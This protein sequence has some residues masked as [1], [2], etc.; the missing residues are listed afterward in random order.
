MAGIVEPQV[1]VSSARPRCALNPLLSM[2]TLA[3]STIVGN[4]SA[5]DGR[6]WRFF[7]IAFFNLATDFLLFG[8]SRSQSIW[9]LCLFGKFSRERRAM[10]YVSIQQ[11]HEIERRRRLLKQSTRFLKIIFSAIQRLRDCF[12]THTLDLFIVYLVYSS[13]FPFIQGVLLISTSF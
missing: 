9:D 7:G 6:P 13:E 2:K 1:P 5:T 3:V 4:I 11:L 12:Y 10:F 8:L